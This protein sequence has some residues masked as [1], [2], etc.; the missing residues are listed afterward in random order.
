MASKMTELGDGMASNA[1]VS[2]T[3]ADAQAFWAS[4]RDEIP[5][6]SYMQTSLEAWDGESL[7]IAAPLAPNTNDKS[8]AFAGSLATLA[9]VTG[10]A[11]LTLWAKSQYVPCWVAAAD[12]HIRYRKP[13]MSDFK[14]IAILPNADDLAGLKARIASHGRDRV[15]VQVIVQSAGGDA[16][17]LEASYAV[18]PSES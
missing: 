16:L 15:S 9:T 10:W 6:L 5:M 8:T 14:A 12:S 3:L 7:C 2:S 1:Q 13:V 17:T 11:I 18:W 4:V